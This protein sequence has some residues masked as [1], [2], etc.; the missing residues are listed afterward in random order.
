M[1]LGAI[2]E[3]TLKPTCS[4]LLVR[5][6]EANQ[7]KITYALKHDVA[8]VSEAWLQSCIIHGERMPMEQ[9]RLPTHKP[10]AVKRTRTDTRNSESTTR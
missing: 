3:S 7:E 2:Y 9:Y 1:V 5:S 8:V 10:V 6:P 4:I